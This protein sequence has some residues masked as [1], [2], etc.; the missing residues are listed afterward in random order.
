MQLIFDNLVAIMIAGVMFLILVG[1]NQRSRVASIESS[2]YYA[3]KQQELNF[4]ETLKRDMQNVTNLL[5]TGEDPVTL[6]FKFQARTDAIDTTRRTIV[7]RRVFQTE[8]DG[9]DLY[10]VQR[11]VDGA[12]DGGSMATLVDWEIVA[13]NDE[14]VAVSNVANARQVFVHFEAVNPFEQGETIDKSRWEATFRPPL[15][16][17]ATSI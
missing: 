9:E 17:Q 12:S 14:G 1:V 3:M 11:F 7:Y 13:Q 10:Q 15:L 5:N 6:E 8:R 2:G 16:Q 4:I